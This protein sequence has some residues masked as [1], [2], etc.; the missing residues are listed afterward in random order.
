MK[1]IEIKSVNGEDGNAVA[2]SLR[3]ISTSNALACAMGE[4]GVGEDQLV[5]RIDFDDAPSY[6]SSR[7]RDTWHDAR[8]VVDLIDAVEYCDDTTMIETWSDH[9][10]KKAET[11]DELEELIKEAHDYLVCECQIG[12]EDEA[13]ADMWMELMQV[14]DRI[15]PYLDID[16]IAKD[17][18]YDYFTENGY[19]FRI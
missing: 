2:Y 9:V 14:D 10:G 8:E 7:L 15:V 16:Y 3:D 4:F 5:A 17:M 12:K 1:I 19:I 11:A 6:L 13:L 18:R